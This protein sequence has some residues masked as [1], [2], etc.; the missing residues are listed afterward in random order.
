MSIFPSDLRLSTLA[1]ATYFFDHRDRGQHNLELREGSAAILYQ[2]LA[3]ALFQNSNR[4]AAYNLSLPGSREHLPSQRV[5]ASPDSSETDHEI[6]MIA[7][8]LEM[9][10]RASADYVEVTWDE[11]G[12]EVLALLIRV[13]ERPFLKMERAAERAV[14]D[15][16]PGG[17]DRAAASAINRDMKLAVQ[18]VTK[19]LAIY[20]LVPEAKVPMC[21]CPRMLPVLV[22][23]IDTA[24]FNR[25][26]PAPPSSSRRDLMNDGRGSRGDLPG[27]P[28]VSGSSSL[29][30]RGGSLQGGDGSSRSL[31]T[32]VS[33]DEVRGATAGAG[34]HMTE[35]AR[36]NV[37]ATLTNLAAAEQNR[38]RMLA[39]PS[40]C[41]GWSGL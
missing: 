3:F 28:W 36:F 37:I 30:N 40:E 41:L 1:Q 32:G 39:E 18:K 21:D 13:L 35:A 33:A 20:S 26:R 4:S 12:F 31:G 7:S 14:R 19:L 11:I 16:T 8:C 38:M 10:H 15:S 25:V 22:K 24:N 23:I 6:A 17:A 34:L 9:V 2:K 5:R 27:N 29:L